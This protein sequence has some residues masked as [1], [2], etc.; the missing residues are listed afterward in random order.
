MSV[1]LPAPDSGDISHGGVHKKEKHA[2]GHFHL[3]YC[4]ICFNI[5]SVFVLCFYFVFVFFLFFFYQCIIS[6]CVFS[7]M[8]Q[9]LLSLDT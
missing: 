7:F 6:C 2:Q 5:H 1:T 4:F 9:P 3:N 8:F